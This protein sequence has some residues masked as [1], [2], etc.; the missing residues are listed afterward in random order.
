VKDLIQNK[1]NKVTI[2]NYLFEREANERAKKTLDLEELILR[3]FSEALQK[4]FDQATKEDMMQFFNAMQGKYALGSIHTYKG[5][6][7]SFYNWLFQLEERQYPDCVRWIKANNPSKRSGMELPIT[8][9]N[10]LTPEEVKQLVNASMYPRDQALIMLTYESAARAEE[11]LQLK[12]NSIVFDEHG[13]KVTLTGVGQGSRVIRL[14][15]SVPYIQTWLNVHPQ[16]NNVEAPLWLTKTDN[17]G[18]MNFYR[19]LRVLKKRT[20]IKKNVRPHLLRHARLT[21]LAKHLTDAQLKTY[22]GWTPSSRMTGVYVHL[23]G[24]DLDEP[25][26]AMHGLTLKKDKPKE[27]FEKKICVRDHVNPG[28]ALYCNVCGIVLDSEKALELMQKESER[29]KEAKTIHEFL[30]NLKGIKPFV[31]ELAGNRELLKQTLDLAVALKTYPEE[32]KIVL[33][34]IEDVKR[35]L[36]SAKKKQT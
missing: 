11:V 4:P 18:Y 1:S 8:R 6:I 16:R 30:E 32:V 19:M 10:I 31:D 3:Q 13:A 25:I 23:S 21:E 27:V 22:A 29:E 26:L 33:E 20:G 5:R 35:N 15:D 14:V 28:E 24:K 12:I 34:A 17:M 7:K 36:K 2:K 9:D